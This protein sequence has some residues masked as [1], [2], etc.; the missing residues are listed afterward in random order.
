MNL[1]EQIKKA[2]MECSTLE[3]KVK[4]LSLDD[5]KISKKIENEKKSKEFKEIMH[6]KLLQEK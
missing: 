5:Q 3:N 2:S 6:S 4:V 1:K